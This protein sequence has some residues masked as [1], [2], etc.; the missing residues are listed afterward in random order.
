M[1]KSITSACLWGALTLASMWAAPICAA[2]L[3]L[4]PPAHVRQV[5]ECGPCGCVHVT[6]DY[7]RELRSTYGVSFDPRNFDQTQPYYHFGPVRAYPRF[8]CDANAIQ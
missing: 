2:E 1:S 5:A 6:Y 7:H 3:Q 4:P 8:W